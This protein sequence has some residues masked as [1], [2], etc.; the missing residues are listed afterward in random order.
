M[1]VTLIRLAI[2]KCRVIQC[3][4]NNQSNPTSDQR[5]QQPLSCFLFLPN[6]SFTSQLHSTT[7]CPLWIILEQLYP[8]WNASIS[9][10][11]DTPVST[12][13]SIISANPASSH[14]VPPGTEPTR[15]RVTYGD[16]LLLDHVRSIP[17]LLRHERYP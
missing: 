7:F 16:A 4:A 9:I 17:L 14:P 8:Q 3:C 15:S 12:A 6:T 5:G 11:P 2:Q 1:P 13:K 10:T